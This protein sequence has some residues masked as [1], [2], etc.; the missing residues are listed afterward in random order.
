MPKTTDAYSKVIEARLQRVAADIKQVEQRRSAIITD[1]TEDLQRAVA[2]ESAAM[3]TLRNLRVEAICQN[4][5]AQDSRG[6][7]VILEGLAHIK[8]TLEIGEW[9]GSWGSQNVG[10]ISGPNATA[11]LYIERIAIGRLLEFS[12]SG[13]SGGIEFEIGNY[14]NS[15]RVSTHRTRKGAL[16]AAC[17]YFRKKYG[18]QFGGEVLNAE[19]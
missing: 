1:L 14:P 4:I 7:G 6:M 10:H 19:L 11:A 9:E 16:E 3:N 15:F 18:V 5:G 17:A 8:V 2:A 13:A 12:E